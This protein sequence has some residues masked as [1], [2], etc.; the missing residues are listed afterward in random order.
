MSLLAEV[1]SNQERLLQLGKIVAR[2]LLD[3]VDVTLRQISSCPA[4]LLQ[5]KISGNE[6]GNCQRGDEE[7][8]QVAWISG[9]IRPSQLLNTKHVEAEEKSRQAYVVVEVAKVDDTAGDGLK[10]RAGA[11]QSKNIGGVGIKKRSDGTG[12]NK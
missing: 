8:Q 4:N 10:S 12:T 7:P 3:R 6:I 11:E 1:A 9:I 5:P 2:C